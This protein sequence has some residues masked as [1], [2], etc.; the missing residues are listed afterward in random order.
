M[1]VATKQYSPEKVRDYLA[2]VGLGELCASAGVPIISAAAHHLSLLS[3]TAMH[4]ED[5]FHAYG[6]IAAKAEVTDDV[7]EIYYMQYGITPQEQI[8]MEE[9]FTTLIRVDDPGSYY[10][11]HQYGEES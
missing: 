2:G 4:N 8:S 10:F 11:S 9:S 1:Q 5:Y 6:G 3:S 7:R